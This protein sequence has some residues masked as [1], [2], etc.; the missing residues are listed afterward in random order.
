MKDWDWSVVALV[1]LA[2]LWLAVSTPTP[3]HRA[4]VGSNLG[5]ETAALEAR[6]SAAPD[7]AEA[8]VALTHHYLDHSAP[9]LAQAA[10]DRAPQSVRELPRVADARARTLWAMG[11]VPAALELQRSVLADCEVRAC[12][13]SLVG[14]AQRRERL[15][16]E[17]VRLGVEDPKLSP[18]RALVAY[19]RS[20]REVRLDIQ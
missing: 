5:P 3:G 19:W 14:R 16:S 1:S 20:S 10:L 11:F 4:F 8:L 17:L 12:S 18:D 7:D 2:G 6:A 9:G 15:L 13:R